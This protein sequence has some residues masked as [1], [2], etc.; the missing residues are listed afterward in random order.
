MKTTFN[1]I[2][3]RLFYINT[4]LEKYEIDYKTATTN[5]DVLKSKI[6]LE[7]VNQTKQKESLIQF[8]QSNEKQQT[9]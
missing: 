3:R 2:I 4:R 8:L 7:R 6:E 5:L 1:T 9:A